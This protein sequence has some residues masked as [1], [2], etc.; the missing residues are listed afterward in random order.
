[1]GETD[2]DL[3]D[4]DAYKLGLDRPSASD[5]AWARHQLENGQFEVPDTE[6]GPLKLWFQYF[7]LV[8]LYS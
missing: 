7:V 2:K 3:E 5:Q 6:E 8:E 1:M 4:V